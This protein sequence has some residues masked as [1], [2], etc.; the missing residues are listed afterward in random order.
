MFATK[1]DNWQ[2]SPAPGRHSTCSPN[3]R[4]LLH[5]CANNWPGITSLGCFG[6]RAV[7]GGDS[8]SSHSNGAAIDLGYPAGMLPMIRNEVIPFLIARSDELHVQAVH[9]YRSGRIWRAGRTPHTEDACGAWWKAQKHSIATGMGQPWANHLHVET[10]EA[11]WTDGTPIRAR[12][13]HP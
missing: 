9:D 6:V 11:G 2:A 1:F 5:Y 13:D 8:P 7:R 12:W 10:T 3:L 4:A